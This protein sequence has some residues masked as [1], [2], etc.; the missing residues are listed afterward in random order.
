MRQEIFFIFLFYCHF[1][2]AS[3]Q[4][5]S[6]KILLKLYNE[7]NKRQ[8]LAI[9]IKEYKIDSEL[10]KKM[11]HDSQIKFSK[12]DLSLCPSQLHEK[13]FI[14]SKKGNL[15]LLFKTKFNQDAYRVMSFVQ[16][17]DLLFEMIEINRQYKK[18]TINR[19]QESKNLH[20]NLHQ[21]NSFLSFFKNMCTVSYKAIR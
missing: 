5:D 7:T 15:L 21:R 19:R 1:F 16:G 4:T 14:I 6:H 3:L 18:I 2:N 17:D 10:T 8:R 12:E 11:N 9:K 20:E 13:K